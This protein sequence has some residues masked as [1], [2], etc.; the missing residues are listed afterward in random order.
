M[1]TLST[2]ILDIALGRPA[3]GILVIL[4]R[5]DH[6]L[7]RA[8]TNPDGRIGDWPAATPAAS[9][10]PA[11]ASAPLDLTPGI[12]CLRFETKPWFTATST[13]TLYPFI[14]IRFEVGAAGHYHIP[15]LLSPFGYS[16]YR[17]S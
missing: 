1:S 6:E 9:A 3:P 8:R 15:L 13:P 17:G 5:D 10:A 4:S 14:E 12:Y 11:V 7:A 16:T 2:H